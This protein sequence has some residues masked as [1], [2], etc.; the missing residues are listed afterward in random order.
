MIYVW[1]FHQR[2][3]NVNIAYCLFGLPEA[4]G[5][6]TQTFWL[7]VGGVCMCVHTAPGESTA[8]AQVQLL[9]GIH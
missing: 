6:Q 7:Q 2:L 5:P 1:N 9:A 3:K 4:Q 8:N